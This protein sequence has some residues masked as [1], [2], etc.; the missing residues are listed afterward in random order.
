MGAMRALLALVM[1]AGAAHAEGLCE[2]TPLRFDPP[3]MFDAKTQSFAIPASQAWC[4][5]TEDNQEKRGTV[6]FVQLR[7]VHDKVLANVSGATGADATHL[8]AA[9]GAFEKLSGLHAA[10]V[11]RGYA[12]LDGK[13]AKCT[14]K[15]KW[16]GVTAGDR[17]WQDGTV[18]LEL[19][20]G[21]K[22]LQQVTLGAGTA[23][24]RGDQQVRTHAIGTQLAVFATVPSCD[25]PPPGYFSAGDAGD[26]Y[27]KDQVSVRLIDATACF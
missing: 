1:S 26:C 3:T 19:A 12:P 11:K 18:V 25:G 20:R 23:Q 15:T 4:D 27:Q 13:L 8:Q 14:V 5:V 9:I 2:N 16:T 10:L 7:D 22:Q 21:G 17:G 24:R 6:A